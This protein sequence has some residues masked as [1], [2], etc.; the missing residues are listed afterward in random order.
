MSFIYRREIPI[1]FGLIVSS[2]ILMHYFTV[3]PAIEILSVNFQLWGVIIA[4][5]ALLLGL[6]SYTIYHG[7]QVMKSRSFYS[8][9]ALIVCFVTLIVGL[10]VSPSSPKYLFLTVSVLKP[11]SMAVSSYIGFFICSAAFRAF[12]ARNMDA[13]I[14]LVSATIIMLKNIPIGN[15]ILPGILPFG[16]WFN[17]VVAL[18]G[19]RGLIIVMGVGMIVAGIRQLLGYE[20]GGLE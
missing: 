1:I 2:T 8:I 7:K 19:N 15:I 9:W 4:S 3:N 11:L 18:G 20:R 13:A 16:E 5:Y 10:V 14:L 6:L 12:K 17:N